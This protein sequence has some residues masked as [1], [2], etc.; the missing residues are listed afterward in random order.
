VSFSDLI[1]SVDSSINK[2]TMPSGYSGVTIDKA[3][4]IWDSNSSD[5]SSW[6]DFYTNA[7]SDAN[8]LKS[9]ITNIRKFGTTTSTKGDGKVIFRELICIGEN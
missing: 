9:T 5:N 7:Y 2:P 1:G 3:R 4:F 8:D 6:N